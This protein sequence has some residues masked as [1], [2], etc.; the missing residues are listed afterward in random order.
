M[1][2]F[3]IPNLL[4]AAYKGSGHAVAAVNNGRLIDDLRHSR[5]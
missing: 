2:V 1:N 5:A 3:P 4:A